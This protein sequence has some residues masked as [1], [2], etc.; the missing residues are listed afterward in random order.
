MLTFCAQNWTFKNRKSA[1]FSSVLRELKGFNK[2]YMPLATRNFKNIILLILKDKVASTPCGFFRCTKLFSHKTKGAPSPKARDFHQFFSSCGSQRAR[3][4][5][6]PSKYSLS[7][8]NIT[9]EIKTMGCWCVQ[10]F[11]SAQKQGFTSPKSARFSSV[12]S[13]N[14]LHHTNVWCRA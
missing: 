2:V 7:F 13:L 6:K 5:R 1:R 9:S 12:F 3:P 14:F 10:T 11:F 8:T 4:Y